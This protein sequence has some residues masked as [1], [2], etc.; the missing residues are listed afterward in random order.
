MRMVKC[1]GAMDC[2]AA[3]ECEHASPHV[4]KGCERD[5]FCEIL[6]RWLDLEH[7]FPSWIRIEAEACCEEGE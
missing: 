4:Q 1:I 7:N 2:P 5:A 3:G 6:T